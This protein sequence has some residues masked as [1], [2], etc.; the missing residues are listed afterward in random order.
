ME[1]NLGANQN[2]IS[3]KCQSQGLLQALKESET[4]KEFKDTTDQSEIE[5]VSKQIEKITGYNLITGEKN[6]IRV[7]ILKSNGIEKFKILI[8]NPEQLKLKFKEELALSYGISPDKVNIIKVLPG[9]LECYFTI[10]SDLK[11][12]TDKDQIS[13]FSSIKT[14]IGQSQNEPFEVTKK[15]L[16][17]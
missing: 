4:S 2:S 12:K 8:E 15:Y 13:E 11:F 17:S 7:V 6:I 10:S 5:N 1:K 14:L 9:S 16:F 3:L